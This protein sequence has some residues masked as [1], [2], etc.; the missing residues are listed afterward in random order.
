ME[1]FCV[2]KYR[3]KVILYKNKKYQ[4]MLVVYEVRQKM[5]FLRKTKVPLILTISKIVIQTIYL[6]L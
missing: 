3:E 4:F 6:K 5:L 1:N 2:I